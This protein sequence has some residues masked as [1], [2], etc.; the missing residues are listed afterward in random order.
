MTEVARTQGG[1][2]EMERG[3][4]PEVAALGNVLKE[5]FNRLGISQSQ[6]AHRV[7]VDKSVVSRFLSGRRLAPQEFV[8]RLVAEVETHVGAPLKLEA[9]EAIRT[10]RMEALRVTDP[11][12]F[13]LE[14]L[15]AE[16]AR[17]RRDA[18]RAHRNVDALHALLEKKEAEAHT[19]AEELDRLRLDWGAELAR[20]QLDLADAERL[21]L[22]AERRSAD[23]RD[24]VLR[25]EGELSRRSPEGGGTGLLPLEAFLG[26]LKAMWEADEFAEA[27]RELTEAAW[28]RSLEDAED[29]LEWLEKHGPDRARDQFVTDIGRLRPAEE[30]FWFAREFRAKARYVLGVTWLTAIS[31][32]VTERN[33]AV[34]YEGLKET[35]LAF[36]GSQADELLAL[37]VARTPDPDRAV[38]LT[39]GALV[40]ER[41]REGFRRTAYALA[42][43]GSLRWH[44]LFAFR[45]MVGLVRAGRPDVAELVADL[46]CSELPSTPDGE[47][48]RLRKLA[49][50][51]HDD[52]AIDILFDLMAG[53]DPGGGMSRFAE[54]LAADTALFDRFLAS[55]EA[56]GRLDQLDEYVHGDLSRY[57]EKWRRSRGD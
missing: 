23:L 6:Y 43:S 7:H 26:Q 56:R 47:H 53:V 29:L 9:K 48:A 15:R 40:H 22:D 37:T 10:Q 25:L 57:I 36:T 42:R 49:E 2:S 17:S 38:R 11:A 46:Y 18:A 34:F 21:R 24:E 3:C 55:L 8:D 31:S 16:L 33:V 45:V 13:R 20:L 30:L 44:R 4:V 54:D 19:A 28:A 50:T 51:R 39:V 41:S 52:V 14:S 27:S 1:S 12:E 5:L 32:R 35:R